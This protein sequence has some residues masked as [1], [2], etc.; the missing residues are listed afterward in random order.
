MLYLFESYRKPFISVSIFITISL[1]CSAVASAQSRILPTDLLKFSNHSDSL[2]SQYPGEKA[3][4][5]FDKP[6]YALGD[7]IWFKAYLLNAPSLILS[8]KSGLLHIDL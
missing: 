1:F 5:Q 3:Y 6:Y 2:K 4:L 7:T 8:A